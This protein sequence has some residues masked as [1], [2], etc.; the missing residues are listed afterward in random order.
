MPV[1][2]RSRHLG[3]KARLAAAGSRGPN[4][5]WGTEHYGS[6][7]MTRHSERANLGGNG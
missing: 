2:S 1:K 6:E 5:S 7:W 4:A 3:G